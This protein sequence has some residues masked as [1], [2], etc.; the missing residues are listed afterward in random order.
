M[1]INLTISFSHIALR[2][3][4]QNKK[5]L[6]WCY[7]LLYLCI[8][9]WPTYSPTV[10]H[11]LSSFSRRDLPPVFCY[12]KSALSQFQLQLFPLPLIP[13]PT[14][15]MLLQWRSYAVKSLCL[16]DFG[17]PP[18]APL[19]HSSI[20]SLQENNLVKTGLV[21]SAIQMSQAKTRVY[22]RKSNWSLQT[23]QTA[24]LMLF[25]HSNIQHKYSDDVIHPY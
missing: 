15:T 13:N 8:I 25:Q 16:K 11:L 18:I 17:N 5:Q 4:K 12:L 10:Q 3:R 7:I 22:L 9:V 14:Y 6:D 24:Q 2:H 19:P 21:F 20:Q 23:K 1:K